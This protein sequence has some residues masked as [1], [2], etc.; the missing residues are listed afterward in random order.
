MNRTADG[1]RLPP[2]APRTLADGK[3]APGPQKGHSGPASA[4]LASGERGRG[5][6]RPKDTGSLRPKE[7]G[8]RA[9]AGVRGLRG[10]VA[11]LPGG[12]RGAPAG[13]SELFGQ[14]HGLG[15]FTPRKGAWRRSRGRRER[16]GGQRLR[17]ERRPGAAVRAAPAALGPGPGKAWEGGDA[18]VPA[19]S[20]SGH[21]AASEGRTGPEGRAARAAGW[22]SRR[23]VPCS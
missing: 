3:R 12:S 8:S 10:P 6:G 16:P 20:F 9:E 13:K 18:Q 4:R 7:K 23:T 5:S 22:L 11:R 1:G 15:V 14:S 19:D 2:G 17:P 21:P